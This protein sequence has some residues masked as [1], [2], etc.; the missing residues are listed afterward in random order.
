MI[1]EVKRSEQKSAHD[2]LSYP[3]SYTKVYFELRKRHSFFVHFQA[4]PFPKVRFSFIF[5]MLYRN[6]FHYGSR[7][8]V[9]RA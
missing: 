2:H 3:P 5:S 9:G 6:S 1:R 7:D 4:V 8:A